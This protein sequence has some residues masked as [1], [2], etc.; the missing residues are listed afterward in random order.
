MDERNARIE[1]KIDGMQKEM[2]NVKKENEERKL[3]NLECKIRIQEQESRIMMLEKEIRKKNII[4][5]GLDEEIGEDEEQLKTKIQK[6][7]NDMKG[8]IDY[9]KS[10]LKQR[11]MFFKYMIEARKAGDIAHMKYDTLE[12]LERNNEN[13]EEKEGNTE[14]ISKEKQ[15]ARTL[16]ERSPSNGIEDGRPMKITRGENIKNKKGRQGE[17]QERRTLQR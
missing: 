9:P 7:M 17:L 12:Q 1:G 6:V 3:E 2:G 11:Q 14:T 5:Q 15:G 16:S 10:V 4:I 8:N 13:K